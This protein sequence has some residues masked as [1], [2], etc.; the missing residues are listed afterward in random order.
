MERLGR[1]IL[2]DVKP[3]EE[4]DIW[5]DDLLNRKGDADFLEKYIAGQVKN[6]IDEGR[7]G[8]FAINIDADWGAGKTFFVDHF[9]Q[10]LQRSG[11][12]V[13]RVNA[14]HDDYMDDPFVAVLASIDKALAPF[15]KKDGT[16]NSAWKAA[17]KGAVPVLGKVVSG[18]AKTVVR[19]Y[20]GEEVGELLKTEPDLTGD[21][22]EK[23]LLEEI[24]KSGSES[25]SVEIENIIDR[26]TQRIID[27]FNEKGKASEDFQSRLAKAIGAINGA[28]PLPFY[29]II[30]ELDRCRPSYAVALLE[31]VKHLFGAPNMAF[32]FATNANQL[33]HSIAGQYGPGFDGF[34]YLKRFFEATYQLHDPDLSHFVAINAAKVISHGVRVPG[35][36]SQLFMR[37]CFRSYNLKARDIKRV[38]SIMETVVISWT[39]Q[40]KI[41]LSI[42]V[43]LAIDFY[44]SGIAEWSHAFESI[45][46]DINITRREDM[47]TGSGEHIYNL[48]ELF[49]EFL[50]VNND[51]ELFRG[52]MTPYRPSENMEYI[53][54]IV[55]ADGE[56]ILNQGKKTSHDDL[57][58]LVAHAGSI[59][60]SS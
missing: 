32:V 26:S 34:K 55:G 39:H 8:S 24:A 31:R 23:T 44:N 3:G 1:G 10:Q 7:E 21:E 36:E 13:A 15:V 30:D 18:V 4:V 56:R 53:R 47:S 22:D 12:I 17:K 25:V 54:E 50:K 27:E 38:L 16:L 28:H 35:G 6:R 20:V 52:L 29:V 46:P 5:A 37:T 42:L 58:S 2:S 14:W 51:K 49:S 48:K 59:T 11:H 40:R 9:A 60:S 43:P 57:I 41:D 45:P 33:R 19:K